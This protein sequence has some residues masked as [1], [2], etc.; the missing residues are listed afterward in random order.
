MPLSGLGHAVWLCCFSSMVTYQHKEHLK[1]LEILMAILIDFVLSGILLYGCHLAGQTWPLWGEI[2][3]GS[4]LLIRASSPVTVTRM[5]TDLSF[6]AKMRLFFSGIL[7]ERHP[8]SKEM[9]PKFYK[10]D[11][12][13]L[14]MTHHWQGLRDVSP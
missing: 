5:P 13:C 10:Q 3:N 4:F 12:T 6:I 11:K 2:G 7:G 1:K 14:L 9:L 8:G